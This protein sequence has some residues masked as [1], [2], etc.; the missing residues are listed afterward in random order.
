MLQTGAAFGPGAPARFHRPPVADPP[1]L[2]CPTIDIDRDAAHEAAQRELEKPIYP[3]ASLIERLKDWITELLYQL[4]DNG[5]SVP[6]GWFTISVLLVLLAVADS[7]RHPRSPGAP[8]APSWRLPALSMTVS[9]AP[10][11]SR[12]RRTAMRPR[13]IGPPRFDIGCARSP[14]SLEETGCWILLLAE[15][16]TNWRA[17][18]PHAIPHLAPNYQR[19]QPHSTT[20]PTAKGREHRLPTR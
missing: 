19:R 2:T 12:Y 6:G 10:P 1:I 13:V 18:P 7:G 14:A 3:K 20:S 4:I 9:S 11:A 15:P 16:P 17:T 8:S 5:S